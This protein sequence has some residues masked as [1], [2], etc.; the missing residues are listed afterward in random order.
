[1]PVISHS[2]AFAV[3]LDAGLLKPAVNMAIG[4]GDALGDTIG[5]T[6]KRG[7]AA[8]DLDGIA[9]KAYFTRA[10]GATVYVDGT[11][12]GSTAVIVLP[13]ECYAYDGP[14]T[15]AV[16]LEDADNDTAVTVLYI[17]GSV[18]LTDSGRV[19][20]PGTVY[21]SYSELM[22]LIARKI[23]EPE[24]EGENGMVLTTDGNGGRRWMDISA[25]TVAGTLKVDSDNYIIRTGSAGAS[26]YF[27]ILTEV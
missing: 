18:I 8:V 12:S 21:P 14:F 17:M 6:V 13:E 11:A 2:Y 9:V 22:E 20:D 24:E 23:T 19:V 16:K 15:L 26:G 25:S 4:A 1:M 5:I 7:G 27:T 10:D 3:D